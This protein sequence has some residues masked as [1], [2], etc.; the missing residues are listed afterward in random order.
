MTQAGNYTIEKLILVGQRSS[1]NLSAIFTEINIFESI[2]SPTLT[3]WVS[4]DDS[5]NLISGPNSLPIMG[6]EFIII[7]V[8]VADH[9]SQQPLSVNKDPNRQKNK[10]FIFAGRVIDIKN[11]TMINE[12]SQSYEIHFASEEFVLDRNIRISKSYK[13]LTASSIVEKIFSEF[14]TETTYEFE[15]T[16]GITNVI[17]PNW[18]PLKTINWL[19]SRALSESYNNPTFFFFQ[20]LYNDGPTSPDRINYTLSSF[21]DSFSNKFWFLSLD[22]MLAYDARKIIYFRPGNINIQSESS[23]YEYANAYNYEV[24]NSFNTL[25]NNANGL[26]NNTLITHDITNKTWKKSVFNYD[27]KF[28][29]LKHLEGNKMFPGLPDS[30]GNRFNSKEYKES[31]IIY[32]PTGTPEN[33]NFTERIS[34]IRTHRLASLD[35]FRIRITLPGDCTLESG[36]IV[37]F[38]LPSPEPGGESKFDEYYRGNLLITHIRHTI[39][40]IQYNITIECCKETIKKEITND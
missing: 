15:K 26:Y 11:R 35:L 36:D 31:L 19:T 21:N 9:V 23:N 17:I 10:K 32:N 24:V 3:G 2:Y 16:V 40:K 12:R 5:L 6:N 8:S 30:K 39:T 27:D 33:P 29:Q 22:D 18:S 1:V 14:G 4:V 37:Y 28:P 25:T 20:T 34:S 7:Q 38:D 13:N